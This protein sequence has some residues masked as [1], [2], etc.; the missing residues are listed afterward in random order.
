MCHPACHLGQPGCRTEHLSTALGAAVSEQT[1]THLNLK[2]SHHCRMHMSASNLAVSH[3]KAAWSASWPLPLPGRAWLIGSYPRDLCPCRADRC[4]S[5]PNRGDG[6]DRRGA[7]RTLRGQCGAVDPPGAGLRPAAAGVERARCR[8]AWLHLLAGRLQG[9]NGP[10]RH[11]ASCGVPLTV[12]QP[13]RRGGQ[14][15][16]L[17]PARCPRGRTRRTGFGL[18]R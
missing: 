7:G 5:T 15:L 4:R 14:A 17:P 9:A 8:K 18:A 3:T 1:W 10:Q 6:A 2:I 13:V 11:E 16:A 12:V